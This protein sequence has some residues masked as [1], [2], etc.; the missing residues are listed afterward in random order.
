MENDNKRS[1]DPKNNSSMIWFSMILVV[2][3]AIAMFMILNQTRTTM[4]FSDFQRLISAT[5]Y[6]DDS[7]TLAADSTGAIEITDARGNGRVVRYSHPTRI[8]V[9]QRQ[10]TGRAKMKVLEGMGQEKEEQVVEFVVNKAETDTLNAELKNLLEDSNIRWQFADGPGI[11]R[12]YGFLFVTMGLIV[13]LFFIM[14]RRL[15]GAGGPMQFGRSRGRLYAE[16]DLGVT[17]DDVAGIDEAVEEVKEVVDFLRMPEK[18]QKLGGTDPPRCPAGRAAGNRQD[19]AGQSDCRRG[20]RS[21]FQPVR[22]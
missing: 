13:L 8:E 3:I 21:V 12:R 20:R 15:G 18:Y 14:M 10:I 7:A 9:G 2:A 4:S 17:F 6:E 22:Q 19:P 5:K 1:T 16:E 11:W